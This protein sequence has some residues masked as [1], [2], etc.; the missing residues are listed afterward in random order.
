MSIASRVRIPRRTLRSPKSP[1]LLPNRIKT[2]L[3]PRTRNNSFVITVA[4]CSETQSPK[5][6]V[7][8]LF[9]GNEDISNKMETV[10]NIG[11]KLYSSKISFILLYR[12]SCIDAFPIFTL[13]R[14]SLHQIPFFSHVRTL[15][16]QRLLKFIFRRHTLLLADFGNL[17]R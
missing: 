13:H 5:P 2:F 8:F 17:V 3:T 7:Y 9:C 11:E 15:K 1:F 10:N 14:R 4:F 16:P 6:S 12:V